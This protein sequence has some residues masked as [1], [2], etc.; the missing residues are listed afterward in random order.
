ME[1]T[2]LMVGLARSEEGAR[3]PISKVSSGVWA[4][5]IP[6]EKAHSLQEIGYGKQTL[7]QELERIG[8]LGATECSFRANPIAVSC[9]PCSSNDDFKVDCNRHTLN[10]IS[11]SE[12]SPCFYTLACGICS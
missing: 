7:K 3:F 10:Y 12:K 9:I 2:T 1:S 11:V 4:G 5:I 8:Y 6:L